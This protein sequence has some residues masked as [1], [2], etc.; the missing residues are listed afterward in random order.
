MTS[1][2]GAVSTHTRH[3]DQPVAYGRTHGCG[4]DDS[5]YQEGFLAPLVE[6]AAGTSP[7]LPSVKTH[8]EFLCGM[9]FDSL[10]ADL[11]FYEHHGLDVKAVQVEIALVPGEL[12]VFDNL[13]L[14]HGRRGIRRPGELRQRVFGH[15]VL[16]PTAQRRLRDRVLRAFHTPQPDSPGLL[17]SVSMP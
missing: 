5:G 3:T 6:A 11:A 16:A 14:A 10:S 4:G 15:K 12:L 2:V 1:I 13:A 17:A 9:E 8:P 7:A